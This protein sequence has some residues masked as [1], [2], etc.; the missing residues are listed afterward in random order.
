MRLVND[1]CALRRVFMG[2]VN[3]GSCCLRRHVGCIV[4]SQWTQ[5]PCKSH[6]AQYKIIVPTP[7]AFYYVADF[8]KLCG[9]VRYERMGTQIDGITNTRYFRNMRV[10]G[11]ALPSSMKQAVVPR[12]W[13]HVANFPRVS[14][15]V[16]LPAVHPGTMPF[17]CWQW[18]SRYTPMPHVQ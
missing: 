6:G 4:R 1:E 18:T 16:Q 17:P 15:A 9:W 11:V 5:L 12:Q 8:C 2:H 7:I 13:R 14:Q 10:N 3:N